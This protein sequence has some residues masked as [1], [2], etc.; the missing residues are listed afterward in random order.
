MTTRE[1]KVEIE[2]TEEELW[3]LRIIITRLQIQAKG[4]HYRSQAHVDADV[5][6]GLLAKLE[7]E[8]DDG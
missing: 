1:R 6:R 2:V 8:G 4:L 5:L 3:T 7:G